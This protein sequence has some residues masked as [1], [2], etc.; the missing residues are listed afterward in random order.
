VENIK[1][2]FR[3]IKNTIETRYAL[4]KE[5]SNLSGIGDDIS[6]LH[7]VMISM[8]KEMHQDEERKDIQKNKKQKIDNSLICKEADV[9]AMCSSTTPLVARK[10]T[11]LSLYLVNNFFVLR[12]RIISNTSRIENRN[13][14][15]LLRSSRNYVF[16]FEWESNSCRVHI[17][18]KSYHE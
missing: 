13:Y 18:F 8:C 2:K 6:E 9:L 7:S 11:I 3:T 5:G 14:I 16:D 10:G 15:Q 12:C 4:S 1:S 17:Y